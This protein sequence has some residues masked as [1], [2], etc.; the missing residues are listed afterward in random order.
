MFDL[1]IRPELI[2]ELTNTIENFT[3]SYK[4]TYYDNM[5]LRPRTIFVSSII[6]HDGEIMVKLL[7]NHMWKIMIMCRN[8]LIFL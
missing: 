3:Y 4:V 6:P 1:S 8:I 7:D 2:D 5:A